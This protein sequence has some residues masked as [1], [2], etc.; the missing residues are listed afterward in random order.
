MSV[1]RHLVI[2]VLVLLALRL[3]IEAPLGITG[4]A[5][6]LGVEFDATYVVAGLLT[7]LCGAL[8]EAGRVGV[9]RLGFAPGAVNWAL[10]LTQGVAA[11]ML[12]FIPPDQWIEWLGNGKLWEVLLAPTTRAIA[13]VWLGIVLVRSFGGGHAAA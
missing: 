6:I 13:G 1:G 10:L 7:A 3:V 9:D 2:V 4:R 5:S 8:I 11:A 12:A